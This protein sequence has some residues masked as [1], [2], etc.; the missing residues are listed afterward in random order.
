M[1]KNIGL[2]IVRLDYWLPAGVVVFGD[3]PCVIGIQC[4]EL[5]GILMFQV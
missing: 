3:T 5:V 4:W 1:L 2:L